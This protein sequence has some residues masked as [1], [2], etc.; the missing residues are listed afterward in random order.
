M[1]Y[2]KNAKNGAAPAHA[3]VDVSLEVASIE[4]L[5][6]VQMTNV[7]D[8]TLAIL[9]RTSRTKAVNIHLR[10]QF[11]GGG[12]CLGEY[13]TPIKYSS[14]FFFFWTVLVFLIYINYAISKDIISECDKNMK[15]EFG[16][17][18]FMGKASTNQD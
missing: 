14:I 3:N 1:L 12:I 11:V 4:A 5:I 9:Y 13:L 8:L 2:L 18:L 15:I 16:P 6:N 17:N 10:I 7:R